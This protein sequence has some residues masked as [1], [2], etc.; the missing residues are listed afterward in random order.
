M[1]VYRQ[2]WSKKLNC[3][4]KLKFGISPDWNMLDF[5]VTFTFPVLE[6]EKLFL[7]KSG[8]KHQNTAQK[9]K[10]SIKDFFS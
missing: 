8:L 5:M 3:I 10:F 6:R 2:I 4:F 9:M 1:T 7:D